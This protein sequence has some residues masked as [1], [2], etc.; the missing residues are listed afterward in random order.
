MN[1]LTDIIMTEARPLH[2]NQI[3]E[4]KAQFARFPIVS[5]DPFR[6]VANANGQSQPGL[7]V[8]SYKG[9]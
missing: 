5:V 1:V 9:P 3:L 4:I 6:K 8:Q 7:F 2:P